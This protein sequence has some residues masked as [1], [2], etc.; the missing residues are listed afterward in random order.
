[1]AEFGKHAEM[2]G[3]AQFPPPPPQRP[4][5]IE[6]LRLLYGAGR[7]FAAAEFAYQS[8]RARLLAKAAVWIAGGG[9]VALTLLFFVTMAL[10]VGLLLALGTVLGPWGALA[11]VVGGLLVA[12]A[13]AGLVAYLGLRKFLALLGDG[14]NPA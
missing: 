11:V 7:Q 1:M 5:V 12:T 8:A 4:P 10:V 2:E 6:E 14:K 13:L 9:A 3:A